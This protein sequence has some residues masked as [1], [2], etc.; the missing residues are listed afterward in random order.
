MQCLTLAL[1]KPARAG[2]YR[3]FNQ[4]QEVYNVTDLALKVQKVAGEIGL[5]API[6]PIE[7]PRQESEE[8]YYNPDHQHLFD[9]GY[10]PTRDV[11]AEIRIMLQDLR[12]HQDRIALKREALLPDVRWSGGRSRVR[13]LT[14]APAAP[15]PTAVAG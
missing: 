13:Y 8:H 4:F 12:K 14:P 15:S 3:V 10:Q 5:E 11:E 7:N 1:E 9:L 2:E 6:A